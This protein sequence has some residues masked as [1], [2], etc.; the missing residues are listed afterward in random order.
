MEEL[1]DDVL[2][3]G[4]PESSSRTEFAREHSRAPR[5]SPYT[6]QASGA[7]VT[8]RE[9]SKSQLGRF[10]N[11]DQVELTLKKDIFRVEASIHAALNAA[12]SIFGR[13][14]HVIGAPEA[15]GAYGE[16]R[17]ARECSRAN[18]VLLEESGKV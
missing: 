16:T 17:G 11:L 14:W 6:P 12:G 13:S 3:T 15:R 10:K 1:L 5:V 4:N 2:R 7:P 8:C 18:S 9:C